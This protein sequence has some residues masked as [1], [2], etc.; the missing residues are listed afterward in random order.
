MK[1]FTDRENRFLVK[2]GITPGPWESKGP[3]SDVDYE[4]L[5]YQK[6]ECGKSLCFVDKGNCGCVS[7]SPAM[8]LTLFHRLYRD[9][10]S[11]FT[12]SRFYH[13]FKN[14]IEIIQSSTGETWQQ[15]CEIWEETE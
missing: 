9:M 8:F 2:L 13:L 4:I 5:S 6:H 7:Q 3:D 15:L 11:T 12:K 10:K 1:Q 14:E